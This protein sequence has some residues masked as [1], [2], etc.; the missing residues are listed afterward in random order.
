MIARRFDPVFSSALR[1][2]L[3][4]LASHTA[5]PAPQPVHRRPQLWISVV[6]ALVLVV[7]TLGALQLAG[8]RT[9]TPAEP[10]ATSTPGTGRIDDLQDITRLLTDPRSPEFVATTLTPLWSGEGAGGGDHVVRFNGP[11]GVPSVRVYIT[12]SGDATFRVTFGRAFWGGCGPHGMQRADIPIG[13]HSA[14]PALHVQ[15]SKGVRYSAIMIATPSTQSADPTV[16]AAFPYPDVSTVGDGGVV[17]RKRGFGGLEITGRMDRAAHG[18]A[19]VVTCE[20]TGALVIRPGDGS[21]LG[22]ARHPLC[23]PHSLRRTTTSI[24][25]DLE[26]LGRMRF[27]IQPHGEATWTVTFVSSPR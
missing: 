16:P 25:G 1:N 24:G 23:A 15:V 7:A 22:D 11:L 5:G 18:L 3:E 4:A 17:A 10:A 13:A 2:E 20:G 12:C 19:V 27:R 26:R 14:A 8:R 21:T 6:T 9:A